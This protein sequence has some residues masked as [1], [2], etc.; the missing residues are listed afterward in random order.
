M[1]LEY[2]NNVIYPPNFIEIEGSVIFLAGP[3]QSA[4][5]WQEEAAQFLYKLKPEVYIANPRRDYPEGEFVYEKQV[6]WETH[7]LRRAEKKGVILFWLAK[8]FKHNCARPYAQ[9]SRFELG[10][11]KA[12]HEFL[13]S[14]LVLGIEKEFSNDRYIK[15]RFSQDCPS[16]PICSSLEETCKTAL[17]LIL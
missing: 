8:E 1:N 14:K 15:R 13:G 6:D 17:E 12:R 10:E 16:V 3:I 2:K 4:T 9:T 11:W 5:V 7:F